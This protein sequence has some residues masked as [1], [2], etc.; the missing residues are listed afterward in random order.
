MSIRL[1]VLIAT[2]ALASTLSSRAETITFQQGVAPDESYDMGGTDFRSDE[3]TKHIY[4]GAGLML[5]G[6]FPDGFVRG[7]LEIDLTPLQAAAGRKRLTI[8]AASL[9]LTVA[10]VSGVNASHPLEI[11][12]YTIS[13][14]FDEKLDRSDTYGSN[15]DGITRLGSVV[16]DDTNPMVVFDSNPAF[17]QAVTAALAQ[18]DNTL[19]LAVRAPAETENSKRAEFVRFFSDDASAANTPE[20]AGDPSLRPLLTIDYKTAP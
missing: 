2:L 19:R 18:G 6:S 17:V 4:G 10:S 15:S 5:T 8:E 12:L 13:E 16:I 14:D 7:A 9:T 3:V 11:E 20:G 1:P